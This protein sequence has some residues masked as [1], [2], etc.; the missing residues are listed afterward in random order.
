MFIFIE[1][2]VPGGTNLGGSIFA[3]TYATAATLYLGEKVYF[4]Y[5]SLADRL[6]KKCVH[7]YVRLLE[8]RLLEYIPALTYLAA[9]FYFPLVML[10]EKVEQNGVE[11][12][13]F[14]LH[15]M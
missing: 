15:I 5:K 8:V 3:V 7:W 6:S 1:K 13:L 14:E 11:R 9:K 2:L 12:R 4:P 10:S